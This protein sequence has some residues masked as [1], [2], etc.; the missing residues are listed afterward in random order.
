M[1]VEPSSSAPASSAAV[2]RP[3]SDN[4]HAST[5]SASHNFNGFDEFDDTPAFP[6][7]TKPA[8]PAAAPQP[9]SQSFSAHLLFDSVEQDITPP[10]PPSTRQNSTV[11]YDFHQGQPHP[12]LATDPVFGSSDF[13]FDLPPAPAS[14]QNSVANGSNRGSFGNADAGFDFPAPGSHSNSTNVRAPSFS[15]FGGAAP[16]GGFDAFSSSSSSAPSHP[17]ITA[18]AKVVAPAPLIPDFDSILPPAVTLTPTPSSAK[19]AN[20]TDLLGDLLDAPFPA[21]QQQQQ[22]KSVGSNE[23]LSLYDQPKHDPFASMKPPVMLA[24]SNNNLSN[25]IPYIPPTTAGMPMQNNRRPSAM[26]GGV[27]PGGGGYYTSPPMTPGMNNIN[28]N[29]SYSSSTSN[30]AYSSASSTPYSTSA[31]NSY[32]FSGTPG[33][34]MPS[35]VAG[36]APKMSQQP[37][38]PGGSV[39][40][41]SY[42]YYSNPLKTNPNAMKP[43][44]GKSSDPFDS[45]NVM[46]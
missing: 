28:S 40:N 26:M 7:H 23:L 4:F 17:V 5:T 2:R 30:S 13:A 25:A 6:S 27:A 10:Q 38:G 16:G 1:Y 46:K 14:R 41:P 42:N 29:M 21:Q 31:A 34:G 33:G 36:Q 22:G 45:L 43:S 39:G 3:S 35:Q 12:A 24:P 37:Q 8:A 18:P 20:H 11:S 19:P 44:Y 15:N 9:A 32:K